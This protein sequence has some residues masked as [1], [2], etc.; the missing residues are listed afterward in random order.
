MD[1]LSNQPIGNMPVD[2]AI[3]TQHAGPP[4][5]M[6][7][8]TGT[9]SGV[10]T[11]SQDPGVPVSATATFAATAT[12]AASSDSK[13]FTIGQ[14]TNVGPVDGQATYTGSLFFWTTS[15]SSSTSTLTLSA[16]I[17]DTDGCRAGDIRKAKVTFGVRNSTGGWSPIPSAQN[18]PVGLVDPA[19]PS[20]GTATAIAQWDIGNANT[21]GLEIVVVIGG[22][23]FRNTVADDK[24]VT[25]SKPGLANSLVGGGDMDLTSVAYLPQ[26]YPVS[27]GYLAT[28]R[29]PGAEGYLHIYADVNYNKSGTNPQ[30]DAT[31][32]FTTYNKPDGSVDT[33]K[34]TYLIKSSSI[35]ELTLQGPGQASFGSKAVVQEVTNP[36]KPVSIDG[37]ATL[38]ITLKDGGS[39]SYD[40][41]AVSVQKKSGGVWISAAWDGVK[42]VQKPLVGG[43]VAAF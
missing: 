34:H 19:D 11:L 15:S 1:V 38:Q 20:V 24:I 36:G 22:N 7:G 4:T 8:N 35:S 18:L 26:S 28:A 31:L 5:P 3:G 12:Y 27:S 13:P 37:G 33:V 16:T 6:T 39:G 23:Y 41:V 40:M 14:D 32:L 30:G 10:I 21:Q 25:I 2:L 29:V 43:N 9:A 17:R 42:T